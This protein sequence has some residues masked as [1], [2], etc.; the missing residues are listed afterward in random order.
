MFVTIPFSRGARIAGRVIS[1]A[2]PIPPG[3]P[4]DIE[5]FAGEDPALA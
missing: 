4:I 2:A 5:A 3:M 1:D